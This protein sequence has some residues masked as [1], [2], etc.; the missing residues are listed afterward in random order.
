MSVF[1]ALDTNPEEATVLLEEDRFYDSMSTHDQL[2]RL[3]LAIETDE[4][5][6]TV[7]EKEP[8]IHLQN[9]IKKLQD[10]NK[11]IYRDISDLRKSF[12]VT[13]VETIYFK[14]KFCRKH[15]LQ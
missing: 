1:E 15:T 9:K 8:L 5:M 6:S 13:I 2:T 11:D 12:Q 14:P 10:S 4:N 7:L 3:A